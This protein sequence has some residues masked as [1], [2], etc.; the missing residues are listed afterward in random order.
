MTRRREL[1]LLESANVLGGVANSLVMVVIP[2]LVL[3]RTGSA[4]AAGLAGA[5]AGLPAIVMAPVVGAVVDRLGRRTVSVVSDLLS[6][7]SVALFPVLDAIGR[8]DLTAI[9]LL[10]VLGAAFDPAGYTAR[11]AMI[12]DVA[13]VSGVDRNQVNGVHEGIFAAGWVVGPMLAALAI[14]TLGSVAAMWV[15]FGAFVLAAGTVLVMR[16]PDKARPESGP[17]EPERVWASARTGLRVLL[18]DR[19]VWLLTLVVAAI[20]LIYMPTES[21]LLPTHF[22]SLGQPGGFGLVLSAMAAGGML[23]AFGYGWLVRRMRLHRIVTVFLLL[24]GVSYVPIA[25]LLPAAW[26]LL[27]AFVFGL[28]WGPMEPLINTVV[29]NRFPEDQHG[30]V[31]GIQLAVFYAAPPLGQLVA[32]VAA[33]QF[34][35]QPVLVAVAAGLLAMGTVVWLLPSLRD[36]DRVRGPVPEPHFP[37]LPPH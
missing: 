29:Q 27:P 30:R 3:E 14:S 12:P 19:P 7:V 26:M 36:L 35:V 1:T 22:E 17:V 9:L 15:A 20:W 11:K 13:R 37:P 4:A 32:G 33:Q 31:Y 28:A 21:V 24:A 10:T 6:A 18:A 5:L 8:L 34:G 16:V 23:G 2:W 25:A